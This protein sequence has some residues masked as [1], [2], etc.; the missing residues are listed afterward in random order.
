M[1][2][3]PVDSISPLVA[4]RMLEAL[5]EFAGTPEFTQLATAFKRV[6]NIARE[7]PDEE[8]DRLEREEPDFA[9]LLHEPAEIALAGELEQ[10][11]PVIDRVLAGGTN[12][13]RALAEAA[14]FGPAVDRFF[15]DV[16]VMVDDQV[17]RRARLRLMKRLARL[18]LSLADI[19]EIVL[20]TES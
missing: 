18:I 11:R 5:P 17:L 7:L 10:R 8:F 2:A 13:R 19:S 20:Q 14:A 12:Y 1:Q 6:K 9:S 4:R 15:T 16:F 3:Q